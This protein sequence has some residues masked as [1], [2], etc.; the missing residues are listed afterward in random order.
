MT[1]VCVVCPEILNVTIVLNL[2]CLFCFVC[3]CFDYANSKRRVLMMMIMLS[4]S[5]VSSMVTE[6]PSLVS[7]SMIRMPKMSVSSAV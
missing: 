5:M 6:R 4:D 3:L 2:F 7:I 1:D